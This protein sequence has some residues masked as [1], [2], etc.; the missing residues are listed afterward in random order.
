MQMLLIQITILL[1]KR[2]HI[3]A[4][5]LFTIFCVGSKKVYIPTVTNYISSKK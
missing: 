5:F 3:I 4:V 2:H 1:A